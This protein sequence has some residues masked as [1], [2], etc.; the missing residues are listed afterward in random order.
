MN[1]LPRVLLNPGSADGN[2]NDSAS[3]AAIQAAMD[4]ARSEERTKLQGVITQLEGTV[5]RLNGEVATLSGE[6][7]TLS[8]SVNKLTDEMAALKAGLKADGGIDPVKL[9]EE[10]STRVRNELEK[11]HSARLAELENSLNEEKA[12]RQNLAVEQLRT[13]LIKASGGEDSMIVELVTGS[14]EAEILASIDRSKGAFSRAIAAAGGKPPKSG[15]RGGEDGQDF[16]LPGSQKGGDDSAELSNVKNM[17]VGDYAKH[18]E[19]LKKAA[20]RYGGS[21]VPLR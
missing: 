17:S 18:R 16:S 11:V 19:R 2:G 3:T 7:D 15:D 1:R 12:H 5:A 4:K 10:T 20:P 13:R 6:R 8:A 14:T 9:L 21:G